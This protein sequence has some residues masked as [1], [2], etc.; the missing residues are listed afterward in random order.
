MIN[1]EQ[2]ENLRKQWREQLLGYENTGIPI[3]MGNGMTAA[4]LDYTNDLTAEAAL[5]KIP[6]TDV[7]N[8]THVPLGLLG[9]ESSGASLEEQ[10]RNFHQ[11][12]MGLYYTAWLDQLNAKL[13]SPQDQLEGNYVIEADVKP[14]DWAT[15][16]D[17]ADAVRAF[18][19]GS[20]SMTPNE[21]R[22]SF[23]G[24]SSLDDPEANKLQFPKNIGANGSNNTP[25]P[26]DTKPPGRPRGDISA[27]VDRVLKTAERKASN[28]K[29]YMEFCSAVQTDTALK[30]VLTDKIG[31][32]SAEVCVS[33]LHSS[34]LEIAECPKGKLH[35]TFHAKAPMLYVTL[36]E[37]F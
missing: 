31:P 24:E 28:E 11:F 18:G 32:E 36:P 3:I 19:A 4:A 34:L 22:T 8:F 21:L 13:I 2:I 37:L 6:A 25:T 16:K 10:I 17:A 35:D 33:K 26:G 5:A 27:I 23:L 9:Y 7:A 12:G 15:L 14:F 20:P 1:Q 30:Q 29:A